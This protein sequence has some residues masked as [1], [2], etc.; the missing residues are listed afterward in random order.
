MRTLA[1]KLVLVAFVLLITLLN[2]SGISAQEMDTPEELLLQPMAFGP[3]GI[4]DLR[5]L[6]NSL[7][8]EG[9]KYAVICR[10]FNSISDT[11][12]NDY[13]PAVNHN[14]FSSSQFTFYQDN[15]L[16][17]GVSPHATSV[18][19]I[20][21][22]EDQYAYHPIVG[23]F[24]YQGVVPKAQAEIF[25]FQ[26]FIKN[27]ISLNI[28][29]DAD[30]ITASLG[31][32]F[33]RWWTRGIESLAE[34]YGI[35][36]VA[37]IGNGTKV[38][39]PV[40]YPGAGSNA[41]GVGVINSLNTDDL[42]IQ[43]ATFALAYPE[44]SSTGPTIDERCKPDIVAPGNCLVADIS[45]P[46]KYEATGNWS[47]FSTPIVAGAAGLLIQKAKQESDLS[48]AISPYGGNCVIKALLLN[49]AIKLPFWHKG[50]LS[51]K[52]DHSTPLDYIQGAGMLN[53]LG[54]YNNLI[55]GRK[56]PGEVAVKGW[57]LNQLDNKI[58]TSNIY[59]IEIDDP[60]D[61]YITVT[62]C[63]NRHYE[64]T[65][66]FNPLP[67]K[68]SDLRLEIWAVDSN[69]PENT[70][71]LDYSD[72]TID[73]V[74]HIYVKADPNVMN[75]EMV[76]SINNINNDNLDNTQRY[77]LAWNVTYDQNRD[78][79]FWYDLNADG[80]VNM[81]DFDIMFNNSLNSLKSSDEYLLG[82]INLDGEIKADDLSTILNI[83]DNT[84]LDDNQI[85]D[86]ITE[87]EDLNLVS[88]AN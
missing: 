31:D 44:N 41:I 24:Y 75:Y 61:K 52:D 88:N 18:C 28:P 56:K 12:Q 59:Q 6:D 27:N 78:S 23:R 14:C 58:I 22:G 83:I 38:N 10:N 46:N 68:N 4:Y 57:D 11:S 70:Y 71:L 37:G 76:L 49:S 5:A 29:P 60:T 34:R 64:K 43:L 3:T 33:D 80:S 40:L 87:N 8:G 67:E 36:V 73:N 42:L 63:W 16:P 19:S 79:N 54:A 15:K 26:H 81:K 50:K 84:N 32:Q 53:T 25:E 20:L 35:V 55:A 45:E 17:Y 51:T 72:S 9:V 85:T 47:S 30:I 86:S 2:P 74:E 62:L 82:D 69:D 77:G 1:K 7:D 21:F 13:R 65:H 66:P 39:D 48:M